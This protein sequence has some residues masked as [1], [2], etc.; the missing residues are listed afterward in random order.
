[1]REATSGG[2][3]GGREAGRRAPNSC[4]TRQ[5]ACDE[6]L[7]FAALPPFSSGAASA[8]TGAAGTAGAETVLQ[9]GGEKREREGGKRDSPADYSSAFLAFLSLGL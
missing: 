8:A 6:R 1:M 7:H 5:V 4:Q 9:L 2:R 3:N